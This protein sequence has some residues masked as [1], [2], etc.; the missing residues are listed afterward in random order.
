MLERMRRY[1]ENTDEVDTFLGQVHWLQCPACGQQGT[2][3]RHGYIY[4]SHSPE[5]SGI[6]AWR[7]HCK[8][9][10][11]GCGR[12]P[13][14]RLGETI[15]HAC[16]T[17]LQLMAFII[18]LTKARSIKAAWEAAEVPFSLDTAYRIKKQLIHSQAAIRTR[19]S[20]RSPPKGKPCA[21]ALLQTL[22]DVLDA[23]KE[24]D[25]VKAYQL[26][27]QTKFMRP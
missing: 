16:F 23:C 12:A 19:L 6:R 20:G 27:F 10:F 11:G 15:M 17:S 18:E 26:R 4:W 14:V 3:R 24:S 25:A 22:S 5:E 7:I 21:S 2:L 1:F 8:P 13:S 9:E